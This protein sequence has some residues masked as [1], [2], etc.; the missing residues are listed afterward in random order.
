MK[1]A[2]HGNV[3]VASKKFLFN[4]SII[5][6]LCKYI[7]HPSLPSGAHLICPLYD[8]TLNPNQQLPSTAFQSL[9]VCGMLPL[10]S[11]FF[12]IFS[13]ITHVHPSPPLN[14]IRCSLIYCPQRSS[15]MPLKVGFMRLQFHF[16][17]GAGRVNPIRLSS[18][19]DTLT[20]QKWWLLWSR[21][22]W[23]WVQR[24]RI[25]AREMEWEA[26]KGSSTKEINLKLWVFQTFFWT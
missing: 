21:V 10:P 15:T 11:I 17:R 7:A 23:Q 13:S 8:I 22:V 16:G 25:R 2:W 9:P 26:G 14:L 12:S 1:N 5:L 18:H 20:W 24:E 4:K 19:G 6:V 3:R